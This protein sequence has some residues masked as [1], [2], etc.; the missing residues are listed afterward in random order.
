MINSK[1]KI[2]F[3]QKTTL[4]TKKNIDFKFQNKNTKD[5]HKK[6]IKNKKD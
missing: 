4:K 2:L 1:K 3:F 6:N 5:T